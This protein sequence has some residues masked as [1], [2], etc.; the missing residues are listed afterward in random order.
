[1]D[2]TCVLQLLCVLAYRV[3]YAMRP[4]ACLA[5]LLSCFVLAFGAVALPPTEAQLL[6][7]CD[8]RSRS[9]DGEWWADAAC[10]LTRGK[11]TASRVGGIH[12]FLAAS[13]ILC[14]ALPHER[15]GATPALLRVL[16]GDVPITA[17]V[18][19]ASLLS[20][21]RCAA[22][23]GHGADVG[24][25]AVEWSRLLEDASVDGVTLSLAAGV[26]EDAVLVVESHAKAGSPEASVHIVLED[27]TYLGS[28]KAEHELDAGSATDAVIL[29][30]DWNSSFVLSDGSTVLSSVASRTF[31][32][33]A[34][35]I[36]GPPFPAYTSIVVTPIGGDPGASNGAVTNAPIS[37]VSPARHSNCDLTRIRTFGDHCRSVRHGRRHDAHSR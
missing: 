8:S 11:Y 28:L 13:S 22:R 25:P 32:Y 15:D 6:R 14:I 31:T 9:E 16:S 27:N 1:M 23:R 24:S 37:C 7:G 2:T 17:Y 3:C 4:S 10:S 5:T 36:S 18:S 33:Y 12:T 29:R 34:F 35:N 20:S 30:Y 26:A 21:G 19:P